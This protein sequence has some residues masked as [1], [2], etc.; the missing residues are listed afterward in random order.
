MKVIIAQIQEQLLQ[1][2][3]QVTSKGKHLRCIK[4]TDEMVSWYNENEES[5][6]A[7]LCR[8]YLS[9]Y[10]GKIYDWSYGKK[11]LLKEK[12]V[13]KRG[14]HLIVNRLFTHQMAH[15][16][17]LLNAIATHGGALDASDTGT[18]KTYV[19]LAVAKSLGIR[20]V[21][22]CPKSVI[23]SWAKASTHI[24]CV[25]YIKN[26][27][28]YSTNNTPFYTPPNSEQKL[29][30][31]AWGAWNFDKP[32]L[33]IWD[34]AHYIK[35]YDSQRSKMARAAIMNKHTINLYLSATIADKPQQLMTIGLGIKAFLPY[36]NFVRFALAQGAWLDSFG[37]WHDRECNR[38][39]CVCNNGHKLTQMLKK[40]LYTD[41]HRASR[42]RRSDIEGLPELLIRTDPV[43]LG[44]ERTKKIKRAYEEAFKKLIDIEQELFTYEST[45]QHKY[46]KA[47]LQ[48]HKLSIYLRARQVS[49]L[50]KI[51][52][53]YDNAVS[54][55]DNNNSVIIF[56]SFKRSA[57]LL[58]TM[59]CDTGHRIG[60]ITGALSFAD[61][62][63]EQGG[64]IKE[65]DINNEEH[66]LLMQHKTIIRDN[67]ATVS[68]FEQ[69]KIR[70]VIAT[71]AAG[72]V[73]IS[74]HDVNGVH[75][76]IAYINLDFSSVHL[77]QALGRTNRAGAKTPAICKIVIAQKTVEAT[78]IA[79]NIQAKLRNI[80]SIND[81]DLTPEELMV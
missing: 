40:I 79:P 29:K 4:A 58:A 31:Y 55:L 64:V 1:Q 18:G 47:E 70:I 51:K 44:V 57:V 66:L 73:G 8:S 25:A 21:V 45:M 3:W 53:I 46:S 12:P 76:R 9:F 5:R 27:E 75:P 60:M 77:R 69:D 41:P 42:M 20:T 43:D 37:V 26:Y 81:E 56:T 35:N 15:G 11:P 61:K 22:I 6:K 2:K 10:K 7:E 52:W 63:D 28:Q 49:E 14:V 13:V 62:K 32:T 38:Y 30:K 17:T 59:L 36:E 54:D 34:E 23:P 74:L 80:D 39:Q 71:L 50:Q 33:L 24:G 67:N 68:Q 19:A 48:G 65:R 72:G 16:Q 78:H